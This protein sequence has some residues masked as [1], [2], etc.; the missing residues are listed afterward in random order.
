MT[1]L[2]HLKTRRQARLRLGLGCGLLLATWVL[3]ARPSQQLTGTSELDI[4]TVLP[5]GA[6]IY[7]ESKDFLGQLQRWSNSG[8]KQRWLRSES[9]A[10][11]EKSRLYLRLSDK[12]Q[13]FNALAGLNVDLPLVRSLAGRQ[14]GLG[15]YGIRDLEFVFIT[16]VPGST[17]EQ[18]PFFRQRPQYEQRSAEGGAYFA[19]SGPNGAVAFAL[20]NNYFLLATN[21]NLL[22]V[23]LHNLN[24]AASQDR[25][26]AEPLFR[27]AL[28]ALPR[29]QD[30]WMYLN[31]GLVQTSRNFRNEWLHGNFNETSRYRAGVV[32]LALQAGQY[33]E[34]RQFLLKEDLTA[35]SS[36]DN[37]LLQGV[38]SDLE[39][40]K[41]EVVGPRAAATAIH[42]ALLNPLRPRDQTVSLTQRQAPY[43]IAPL[44]K[45]D[46]RY[47]LQIDES[48][49]PV[50]N[51]LEAQKREQELMIAE[52]EREFQSLGVTALVRCAS[53][54]PDAEGYLRGRDAFLL[55]GTGKDVASLK[56]T[57]QRHYNRL[58][59]AGGPAVWARSEGSIEILGHLPGLALGA[60]GQ[61]LAIGNLPA[62]VRTLVT[63]PGNPLLNSDRP[64]HYYCRLDLKQF[65][66]G[67]HALYQWIDYQARLRNPGEP[68]PFFS[69]N[70]GSLLSALEPVDGVSVQRWMKDRTLNEEVV[71]RGSL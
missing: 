56:H 61:W 65:R 16:K 32:R 11:F 54:N 59:H 5:P 10:Q 24:P 53:P 36:I 43:E 9:F 57:L 45:S 35:A 58:Y 1:H 2:F 31:M 20:R 4:A 68:P 17:F 44:L 18:G 42:L 66:P 34:E 60:K 26:S 48:A 37:T 15:L 49:P 29:N 27:E 3:L 39:F 14:A 50:E 55:R 6:M 28:A 63:S 21:E 25:L 70:L 64:L 71:Y 33:R 38:P 12:L 8:V 51:L 23:A 47:L 41:A 19:R 22:R 40:V 30:V 46:N 67:Y 69:G 13:E 7:L 52:L 62:F